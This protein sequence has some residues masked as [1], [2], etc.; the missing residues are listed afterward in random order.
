MI[1]VYRSGCSA[2]EFSTV[3]PAQWSMPPGTLW[4]DLINP[5]RAEDA[6]V[7]RALGLSVPTREE[8]A[9]LEASSRVYRENGVTYATA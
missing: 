9:E 5:T 8:M 2:C 4:I 1:R 7:E 3:D 6:A